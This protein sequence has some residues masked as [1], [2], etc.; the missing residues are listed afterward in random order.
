MA[1]DSNDRH[2]RAHLDLSRKEQQQLDS[3]A[4]RLEGEIESQRRRTHEQA[5]ER[6]ALE[7]RQMDENRRAMR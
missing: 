2:E 6:A 4:N 3:L 1:G 7:Q 5:V